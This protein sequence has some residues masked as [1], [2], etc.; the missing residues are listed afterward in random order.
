MAV[1]SNEGAHCDLK[2][3]RQQDFLPFVCDRCHG[4]FC[5]DHFRYADHA[6]PQAAGLDNRVLVCPLC[7][8]GVK[9]VPGEDPDL[10]WQTHARADCPGGVSSASSKARCP[11]R[12]CKEKLTS[13]NTFNCTRCG[14]CVCLKHRFEDAHNCPAAVAAPVARP[15]TQ[16]SQARVVRNPPKGPWPCSRC[17]LM[18][19]ASDTECVACGT[20]RSPGSTV[21]SDTS[22][23]AAWLCPR[24]TLE[25]PAGSEICAACESRAPGNSGGDGGGCILC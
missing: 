2:E 16:D 5:L 24:C 22:N 19:N 23:I 12:N 3:C 8:K 1:L 13:L 14:A 21:G 4:K 6:C 11:V 18:N 10:T 17:T 25:N 20:I 9:L 15:P 7:A